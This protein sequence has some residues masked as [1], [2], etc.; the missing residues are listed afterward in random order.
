MAAP[1]IAEANSH[2]KKTT[3]HEDCLKRCWSF[4]T[5][6]L[7]L[8]CTS[9]LMPEEKQRREE[10]GERATERKMKTERCR[11]WR[12][13]VMR[14]KEEDTEWQKDYAQERTE[15]EAG[16]GKEWREGNKDV[17]ERG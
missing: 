1:D 3:S 14:R 6:T 16:K 11:E 7:T 10:E 15:R 13:L 2:V 12:C 8:R 9:P 17:L 4:S 5:S